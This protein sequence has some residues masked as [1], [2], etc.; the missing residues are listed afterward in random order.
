MI[1]YTTF[2]KVGIGINTDLITLVC[3]VLYRENIKI[4]KNNVIRFLES[5]MQERGSA[6]FECIYDRYEGIQ[7]YAGIE[8]DVHTVMSGFGIQDQGKHN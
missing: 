3:K 7:E 1:T 4:N 2:I 6:G 5:E 8:T